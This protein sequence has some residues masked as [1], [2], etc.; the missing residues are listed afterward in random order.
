[1]ILTNVKMF[2][3]HCIASHWIESSSRTL[4]PS[5]LFGIQDRD[6]RNY[7]VRLA[8]PCTLDNRALEWSQT[9]ARIY[10]IIVIKPLYFRFDCRVQLNDTFQV[11]IT[12]LNDHPMDGE[13][14]AN[15]AQ[16]CCCC[17]DCSGCS[18]GGA[19]NSILIWTDNFIWLFI[20]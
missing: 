1:M 4:K 11:L 13:G 8:N 7:T 20:C 15:P 9:H 19:L 18:C 2:Q 17:Y 16:S 6:D 3:L 12:Y 5:I 14:L 10:R